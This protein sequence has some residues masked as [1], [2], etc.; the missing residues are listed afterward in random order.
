[1]QPILGET[2][3]VDFITSGATGAAVDA[4]STPTCEVFEDA[5]D[6]AIVTPTVTKRTSKTGNYRIPIVCTA[7]NGFEAGKSYNVN[8]SATVGG[9]AAKATVKSFILR[10]NSTDSALTVGTNND[11]AG[12]SIGT[13]GITS[14]SFA[15]GAIDATAIATDAIGSAELATTAVA[16]IVSA[17]L[18]T[19]MTESYAADGTAPTL[20]QSLFL[21][22]QHLG[23]ASI[24]S[25][26]KTVKKLDG[27]TT[28]ATFTL[29]SATAPTSITR[30]T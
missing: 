4:D 7:G 17:V 6:T 12:Y 26:T 29:D 18:T 19:Q 3:V 1:M 20:A 27:S 25:T 14:S 16:E 2:I 22:Q 10:A 24:S 5:T 13:G 9:V 15:A 28:A 8:V 30:T 21:I 11:K 23:D